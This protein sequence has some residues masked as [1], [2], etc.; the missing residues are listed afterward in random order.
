MSATPT[1]LLVHWNEAEAR[2]MA[3]DLRHAGQTV[4]V[5]FD[6]RA[7]PKTLLPIDADV[8]VISLRRL[9]AQG[10]ELGA[11]LRRRAET[12]QLPLVYVVGDAEKTERVRKLLPDAEFVQWETIAEGVGRGMALPPSNPIVP[13]TMD[14]YAGR[15][16]PDKLGIE[17][18]SAVVILG[19]P[20]DFEV[21]GSIAARLTDRGGSIVLV[22]FQSQ[23]DME[24]L[25]PQAIERMEPRGRLW[26]LWQKKASGRGSDL[27][28]TGVRK[29]GLEHGLVDYKI[30]S[31]DDTW[32]GLCFARR[33]VAQ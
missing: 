29:L 24:A 16:L 18:S 3:E 19:L 21:P 32:S 11:W 15:S 14:A 17:N 2:S 20:D 9:P 25:L 23:A 31:I 6:S 1:I 22:F 7:N 13:G 12:R 5:H 8:V 4:R 33:A 10:R 27:S 30:A 28:E 26:A